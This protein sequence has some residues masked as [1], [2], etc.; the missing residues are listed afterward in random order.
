MISI[1]FSLSVSKAFHAQIRSSYLSPATIFLSA[2]FKSETRY[3]C[4]PLS[5]V[6]R[7]LPSFDLAQPAVGQIDIERELRCP[8]LEEEELGVPPVLRN[9]ADT[10]R[11]LALRTI[12]VDQITRLSNLKPTTI[13]TV[14]SCHNGAKR[15]QNQSANTNGQNR[16]SGKHH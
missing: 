3:S 12:Q 8:D 4:L 13:S 2:S 7:C 10:R 15:L 1:D 11:A 5:S 9:D 14:T 16:F 6:L